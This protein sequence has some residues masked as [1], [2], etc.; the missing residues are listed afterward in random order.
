MSASRGRSSPSLRQRHGLYTPYTLVFVRRCRA[1]SLLLAAVPLRGVSEE[2]KRVQTTFCCRIITVCLTFACPEKKTLFDKLRVSA[3]RGRSSPSLR[4][5]HGG[6]TGYTLACVRR[7]RALSRLCAAVLPRSVSEELE[8][9]SNPSKRPSSCRMNFLFATIF[10][11]KYT[12][13]ISFV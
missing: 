2:Q 7:Y 10:G 12:F 13:F 4:Q 5:R 1:F 8:L 11:G 6:H 3:A 9:S